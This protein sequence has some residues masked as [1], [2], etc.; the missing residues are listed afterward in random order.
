MSQFGLTVL[1]DKANS[2]AV[3]KVSLPN[4]KTDNYA[5]NTSSYALQSNKVLY[6]ICNV[7]LQP[8]KLQS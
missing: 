7:P 8:A 3:L 4:G 6:R 5:I 1:L 2:T